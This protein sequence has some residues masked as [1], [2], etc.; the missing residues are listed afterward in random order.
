MCVLQLTENGENDV[1]LNNLSGMGK[2]ICVLT[3]YIEWALGP[4][5][6]E[7]R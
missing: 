3:T 2:M 7:K 5:W 4:T 6:V 1:R